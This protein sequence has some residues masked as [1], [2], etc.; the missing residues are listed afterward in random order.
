M[1]EAGLIHR[2]PIWVRF[3]ADDRQPFV[4]DHVVA[5]APTR[6]SADQPAPLETLHLAQDQLG[7]FGPGRERMRHGIG[8][9]IAEPIAPLGLM[10]REEV[11]NRLE[12]DVF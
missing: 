5:A 2:R 8:K 11:Q 9:I 4:G 6:A 10:I 7:S 3:S 1:Q 12:R